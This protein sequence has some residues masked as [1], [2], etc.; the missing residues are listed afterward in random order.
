MQNRKPVLLLFFI[1]FIVVFSQIVGNYFKSSNSLPPPREINGDSFAN[2][3][4]VAESIRFVQNRL[5]QNPRDAV[6]YTLLG[7][8]YIRQARETGDVSGYQR[9]EESLNHALELLPKYFPA[10]TLLASVYYSRHEFDEALAT[11]NQALEIKPENPQAQIIVADAYLALG[12]Y[13]EAEIIFQKIAEDN[14]TPSVLARLANLEELKGNREEALALIQRAAGEALQSGGTKENAAWYVLR[15]ADMYYNQGEI[16]KAGEYYEASL[17]VYEN[18]YLALAGLG[19]VSAAQ[20][21][22]EEAISYYQRAV[23]IVPQPDYLAALGDLYSLTG[24]TDQ[25]RVQY[26]TVEYIGG[27][28]ELN[29]QVYNRQLANF[30]SDHDINLEKALNL[31]LAELETRKDVYGYDAAAW[32][33]YKNGNYQRAQEYME[34]AMTLG[35]Q[36]ARLYFHAGMIAYALGQNQSAREYLER[37]MDINPHFSILDFAMANETLERLQAAATK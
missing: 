32:A 19:K 1:L 5:K 31:S 35:T 26:D 11:A 30:Y 34:Q 8:L 3:P 23:N 24:E 25:A 20:G 16:R 37:A 17:R 2:I 6:S 18:Y 27:L 13:G 10:T 33:E 4:P 28:A 15:V 36:D 9:A 7:D 22:Y 21:K 29:Q 12:N 14:A